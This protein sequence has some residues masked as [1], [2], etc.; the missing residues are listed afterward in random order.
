MVDNPKRKPRIWK[1]INKKAKQIL[2]AQYRFE[3]SDFTV[4][5]GDLQVWLQSHGPECVDYEESTPY[6]EL[7]QI[8][9]VEAFYEDAIIGG[10]KK[11]TYANAYHILSYFNKK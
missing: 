4:T 3:E 10:G 9:A 6:E 1:K 8:A 11:N 5:D 7:C 2:L